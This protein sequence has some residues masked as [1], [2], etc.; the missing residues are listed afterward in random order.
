MG[1]YFGEEI[2]VCGRV[3]VAQQAVGRLILLNSGEATNRGIEPVVSIIVIALT[4]LTQ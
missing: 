4:D 3:F 2:L 1:D